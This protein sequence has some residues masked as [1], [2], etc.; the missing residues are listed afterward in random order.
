MKDAATPPPRLPPPALRWPSWAALGRACGRS[1]RVVGAPWGWWGWWPGGAG[2]RAAGRRLRRWAVARDGL[3][4]REEVRLRLGPRLRRVGHPSQGGTRRR[5]QARVPARAGGGESGPARKAC[6][7]LLIGGG[8]AGTRVQ[9]HG[10]AW[11]AGAFPRA[12]ARPAQLGRILGPKGG[13]RRERG[14][15]APRGG[16]CHGSW[17][18][19]RERGTSV[20]GQL[21]GIPSCLRPRVWRP[22]GARRAAGPLGLGAQRRAPP[23]TCAEAVAQA[24]LGLRERVL[25]VLAPANAFARLQGGGARQPPTARSAAPPGRSGCLRPF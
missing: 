20:G 14:P 25:T 13:S 22:K 12:R 3:G 24:P 10:A 8:G 9:T 23:P 17:L 4:L 21:P 11:G 19:I 2:W 5:D 6:I 7:L 18:G 1:C 15:C 16:R